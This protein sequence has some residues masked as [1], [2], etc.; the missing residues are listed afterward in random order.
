MLLNSFKLYSFYQKLELFR[1]TVPL[2]KKIKKNVCLLDQVQNG[3]GQVRVKYTPFDSIK[4]E[5]PN[6]TA[7]NNNENAQEN[8]HK[9]IN[10][11]LSKF[12]I[13]E[14]FNTSAIKTKN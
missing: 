1:Y 3:I 9:Q 4:L 2:K 12:R 7:I 14:K 5:K 6:R 13:Q 11:H 10:K 8:V